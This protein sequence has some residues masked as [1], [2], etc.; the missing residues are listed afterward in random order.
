ML[1]ETGDAGGV[2]ISYD[3]MGNRTT[4]AY[5]SGARVHK[6]YDIL[7]RVS[8]VRD[9][10][11]GLI[12]RYEYSSRFRRR[13]MALGSG[14]R[15]DFAYTPGRNR[16]VSIVYQKVS[17]GETVVG[18]SYTHDVLGNQTSEQREVPGAP[19]GDRFLYDS[20]SRLATVQYDVTALDDP[21]SPY[22]QA[23]QFQRNPL[24]RWSEVRT[25]DSSGNIVDDVI[26][27]TNARDRYVTFGTTTWGYDL[28]GNRT[29]QTVAGGGRR[30][31]TY[32]FAHRL[33][34][35]VDLAP[36][37]EVVQTID[38]TYDAFGRQIGK[39]KT[40]GKTVES[41]T[42][43]WAGRQLLEEHVDGA[44][45]RVYAYGG[46][47]S[48]VL[49]ITSG[50]KRSATHFYLAYNGR[51]SVNALLDASG[52]VLE[53][54]EYDALGQ[55]R[56]G[57]IVITAGVSSPSAAPRTATPASPAG[58]VFFAGGQLFDDDVALQFVGPTAFDP[59]TDGPINASD[60]VSGPQ[61]GRRAIAE[62]EP[63][64]NVADD[65][66][67][68]NADT[69]DAPDEPGLKSSPG[70]SAVIEGIKAGVEIIGGLI[71]FGTIGW[72]PLV[73]GAG[74]WLGEQIIDWASELTPSDIANPLHIG[75]DW[76]PPGSQCVD[77]SDKVSE[78]PG[79]SMQPSNDEPE[80]GP[81]DST[82]GEEN[83]Q[84]NPQGP[85]AGADQPPPPD[86]GSPP[87]ES[88]QSTDQGANQSTDPGTNQSTE[89]G[90]GNQ[91]VD[92]GAANQSS[93]GDPSMSPGPTEPTDGGIGESGG[94][95]GYPGGAFSAGEDS[96]LGAAGGGGCFVA[97]TPIWTR[98]G[99]VP[100]E[101]LDVADE[102][103]TF[104]FDKRSSAVN[105][106]LELHRAE[107]SELLMIDFGSEVLRCT[108]AHRFYRDGWI[109]AR[110][111]RPGDAVLCH[112]GELQTIASITRQREALEV[113][114]LTVH[115]T[116]NYCVG[117]AGIIVHND[118]V[119]NGGY[120]N[121]NP[122]NPLG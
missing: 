56:L 41:T 28:N 91:S 52:N 105:S 87:N 23:V 99:T 17:D 19:G 121:D 14:V 97:G 44:P 73:V 110:E 74:A 37:G 103:I 30:E 18:S 69:S 36:N 66:T 68:E 98:G 32:D 47:S 8:E 116:R 80:T 64:A 114:N 57:G 50:A 27:T 2:A 21:A 113:Y 40:Q 70:G 33:V 108:P 67:G 6:S 76:I 95:D 9:E 26:P 10:K 13:S 1:S 84:E 72:E 5:P 25:L 89:P 34:R 86:A 78:D 39:R 60:R 3:G 112:D 96:G 120:F 11:R 65:P 49:R 111:L 85:D 100:I 71:I 4:L 59:V 75:D 54:Y 82:D 83:P 90:T 106:V 104:D 46:Q 58:N 115:Q 122:D 93:P 88:N 117:S 102:V 31:Y 77:E 63:P 45:A 48:E 43:V 53:R 81:V 92:P 22:A 55:P 119:E 7:G 79:V 101:Q 62:A 118:K 20:S 12:A 107:R 38:Y 109:E 94:E 51:R 61:V 42:R 35:V 29:S 24:G 16:I 15:T